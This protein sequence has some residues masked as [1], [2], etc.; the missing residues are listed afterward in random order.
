MDSGVPGAA[1]IGDPGKRETR[2]G[3]VGPP[4]PYVGSLPYIR[5]PVSA[6][7]TSPPLR[8]NNPKPLTLLV[9]SF[10]LQGHL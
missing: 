9:S 1:H 7:S 4:G 10:P 5:S 2:K 8:V 6:V 3:E